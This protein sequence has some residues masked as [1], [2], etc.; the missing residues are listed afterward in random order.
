LAAATTAGRA[1]C[2]PWVNVA[3]KLPPP[4]GRI[5]SL[6]RSEARGDAFVGVGIRSV[7]RLSDRI[8]VL[9]RG[10]QIGIRETGKTHKNEIVS[11][12]MGVN[13][14]HPCIAQ[15]TQ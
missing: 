12:I 1:G 13:S 7:F 2:C 6:G 5:A 15:Q 14:Q 8:R 11:M 9:G 10:K 3:A 4:V